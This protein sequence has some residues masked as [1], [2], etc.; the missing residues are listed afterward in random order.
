MLA[1]LLFIRLHLIEVV[2]QHARQRLLHVAVLRLGVLRDDRLVVRLAVE[3]RVA[4]LVLG[5][6]ALRRR[7]RALARL[8]TLVQCVDLTLQ[9]ALLRLGVVSLLG[10]Q[11]VKRV[12]QG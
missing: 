2:A 12:Y 8:Q 7:P 1:D 6:L 11:D 10:G 3:V 4:A 5:Q 9:V